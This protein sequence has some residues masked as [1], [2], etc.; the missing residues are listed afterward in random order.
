MRK[1]TAREFDLFARMNQ[2]IQRHERRNKL[3][4]TYVEMEHIA[5]IPRRS[6]WLEDEIEHTP[7][8]WPGKAAR[9]F[10]SRLTPMEHRVPGSAALE[11]DLHAA[12]TESSLEAIE[13]QAIKAAVRHGCSFAFTS[14]GG[15][16]EPAVI[17]TVRSARQATAILDPRTR[18]TLAALED[19]GEG[20]WNLYEPGRVAVVRR[21]MSGT[22]V[23][24]E[25]YAAPQRVMCSPFIHDPDSEK[26]F[27]SSRITREQM[28]L[29]NAGIRTM[30]RSEVSAD[31]YQAPRPIF[32]GASLE[33]LLADDEVSPALRKRIG[34]IWGIPDI[35]PE[36]DLDLPDELRR[37]DM[38]VLPQ[39]SMQPFSDQMRMIVGQFSQASSLPLH[40]LGFTHDANPQS[41]DAI[42]AQETDLIRAVRDQI[43]YFSMARRRYAVDVLTAIYG[44]L[45]EGSTEELRGLRAGFAD[46]KE[47]SASEASQ[48]VQLQTSSGNLRPGGQVALE[49]LPL[50]PEQRAAAERENRISRGSATLEAL[51]GDVEE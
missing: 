48:M 29:T 32:R 27:G 2:T 6:V 45:D 22:L 43:P 41:A 44:D 49:L 25:E 9:V 21:Q 5:P 19:I 10:G 38:T 13:S 36:D 17:S 30:Y 37:V 7:L 31:F 28:S 3:R 40:Y 23:V 42:G 8:N 20:R 33:D 50:T 11:S 46:P 26:P 16:G 4:S 12:W 15:P 34:E 51:R 18:R 14:S 35:S 1:A 47:I 39:M 24:D